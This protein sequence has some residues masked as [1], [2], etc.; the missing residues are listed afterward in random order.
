MSSGFC[1]NSTAS[2]VLSGNAWRI[3]CVICVSFN[4][5]PASEFY[6]ISNN[7][8][9]VTVPS[10]ATTGSVTVT[11]PNGSSTSSGS[12]TVE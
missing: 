10:G 5:V 11:T 12:F 3:G 8:V 9:H 7:Y 6:N 4:G 2:T 1:G